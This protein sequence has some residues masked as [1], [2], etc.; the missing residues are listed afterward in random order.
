M[1]SPNITRSR[2]FS[3][4]LK[5]LSEEDD[6]TTPDY[7][8]VENFKNGDSEAGHKLFVKHYKMVLKVVLDITGGR[9]YDDDHMHAGAVG[10]YEAAKRFD[11]TTGYTFLTYATHWIRKYILIEVC[12]DALPTAGISLGRDTRERLY[13]F[14]GLS[15]VGMPTEEIA[16]VMNISETE[17]RRLADTALVLSR[18]VSLNNV[19]NEDNEENEDYILNGMP[20]QMSAEDEYMRDELRREVETIVSELQDDTHRS[21]LNSLLGLNGHTQVERKELAKH[22]NLMMLDFNRLRRGAYKKLKQELIKR[23][24]VGEPQ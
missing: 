13:R 6:I 16:Q 19:V 18:P 9:W 4:L 3:P 5:A 15:M 2:V 24:V 10:M 14:I 23:R 7:E 21:I 1:P 12:N 11:P 8:L 17:A 20:T 22:M